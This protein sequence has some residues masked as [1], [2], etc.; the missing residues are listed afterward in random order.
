M[1]HIPQVKNRNP[2]STEEQRHVSQ[3]FSQDLKQHFGRVMRA[4]RHFW[5]C[6]FVCSTV[7]C[8]LTCVLDP[9]RQSTVRRLPF[10]ANTMLDLFRVYYTLTRLGMYLLFG[11]T[12]IDL[13]GT[14]LLTRLV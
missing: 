12:F 9:P 11:F 1:G 10:H 4:R 6:L 7:T 5:C 8:T 3:E 13:I 14:P 2:C